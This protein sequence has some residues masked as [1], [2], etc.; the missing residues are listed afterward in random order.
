[1]RATSPLLV[2]L[3]VTVAAAQQPGTPA[4]WMKRVLDPRSIGVEPFP[5]GEENRKF[6][7]D[8]IQLEKDPDKKL[9]IYL[10]PM[11]AREKASK[12][13]QE[14]LGVEPKITS[15]GSEFETH[16]FVVPEKHLKVVITRSQWATGNLQITMEHDP[17]QAGE[18]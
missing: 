14:E 12:H 18:S 2:V 9:N 11:E 10:A 15:E 16:T 3:L 6:A 4:A 13:F 8:M 5:G 17:P 7:V 1:M